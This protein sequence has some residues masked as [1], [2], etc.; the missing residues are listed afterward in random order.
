MTVEDPNG[1]PTIAVTDLDGGKSRKPS[2]HGGAARKTLTWLEIPEWQK[3]NE[4]ILSG[5]RRCVCADPEGDAHMI[6][7]RYG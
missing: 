6:S 1:R 7:V 4:Y 2:V 3:D 5:Y